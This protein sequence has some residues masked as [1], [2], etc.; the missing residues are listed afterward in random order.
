MQ[1]IDVRGRLSRLLDPALG[2]VESLV[3]DITHGYDIHSLHAERA[4]QVV[5]A[6]VAHANKAE[7]DRTS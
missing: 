1:S 7:A 2:A 4:I 3:V 5:G 6:A